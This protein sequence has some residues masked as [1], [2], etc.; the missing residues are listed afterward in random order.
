LA[1]RRTSRVLQVRAGLLSLVGYIRRRGPVA[2]VTADA[3]HARNRTCAGFG[4]PANRLRRPGERAR[5]PADPHVPPSLPGTCDEAHASAASAR[6]MDAGQAQRLALVVKLSIQPST[7]GT[8]STPSCN[9]RA[10]PL[11]DAAEGWVSF[12]QIRRISDSRLPEADLRIRSVSPSAGSVDGDGSDPENKTNGDQ[13]LGGSSDRRSGLS[14]HQLR[15][16]MLPKLSI[17]PYGAWC[18]VWRVRLSETQ[19]SGD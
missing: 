8:R 16:Y 5:T 2:A 10:R 12:A 13:T 1:Q 6:D 3:W 15:Q 11:P 4:R 9:S 14:V 19:R 7:D 18:P 17:V